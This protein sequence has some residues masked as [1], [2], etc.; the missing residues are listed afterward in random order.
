LSHCCHFKSRK[1][2]Q[3]FADTQPQEGEFKKKLRKAEYAAQR[4]KEKKAER[5]LKTAQEALASLNKKKKR[6][7]TK[8]MR[9]KKKQRL[10]KR[11]TKFQQ[12][13][14]NFNHKTL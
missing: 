6:K 13:I 8:K 14:N 11:M 7:K 2:A 10:L 3:K 12:R 4:D 9:K 5:A 1:Q